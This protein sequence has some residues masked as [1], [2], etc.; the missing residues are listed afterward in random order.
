[1]IPKDISN[2]AYDQ[3]DIT[4]QFVFIT[5]ED[6]TKNIVFVYTFFTFIRLCVITTDVNILVDG[7]ILSLQW[8][9]R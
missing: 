3:I 5:S 2:K 9:K 7:N 6:M 1:M 4:T 8:K